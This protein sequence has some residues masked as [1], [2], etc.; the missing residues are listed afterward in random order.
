MFWWQRLDLPRVVTT[1]VVLSLSCFFSDKTFHGSV[2]MQM[3]AF[4]SSVER[5]EPSEQ[6]LEMSYKKARLGS[7]QRTTNC[8]SDG[9]KET[10]RVPPGNRPGPHPCSARRAYNNLMCF[11]IRLYT[12]ALST[13]KVIQRKMKWR[14]WRMV[15]DRKQLRYT[16][17]SLIWIREAKCSPKR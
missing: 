16:E 13:A 2:D 10:R 3:N 12:D 1:A 8:S 5:H 17:P 15:R 14:L 6:F 4:C 11:F 7:T 9:R